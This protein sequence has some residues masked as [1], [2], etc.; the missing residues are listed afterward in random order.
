VPLTMAMPAAAAISASS[1]VAPGEEKSIATSAPDVESAL[2]RSPAFDRRDDLERLVSRLGRER[3]HGA[4]HPTARAD[5]G[6]ARHLP[7]H[8]ASAAAI[9]SRARG[10][11][12]TRGPRTTSRI[13]PWAAS[14]AFTGAG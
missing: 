3:D 9:V 7:S 13:F 10:D 8:A 1:V 12:A 5:D 11:A 2:R 4:P 6:D 14:A